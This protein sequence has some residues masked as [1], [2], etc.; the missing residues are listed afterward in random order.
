L[1]TYHRRSRKII[2]MPITLTIAAVYLVWILY[3]G[4]FHNIWVYGIMKKLDNI[5]RALFLAGCLTF[6]ILIY[7][8]GLF[9]HKCFWKQ[10]R[11]ELYPKEWSAEVISKDHEFE[12]FR[13]RQGL[14]QV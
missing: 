12:D 13:V 11:V 4:N 3:L 8:I 1:V 2:E 5:K 7:F 9:I 6:I 10:R 14:I